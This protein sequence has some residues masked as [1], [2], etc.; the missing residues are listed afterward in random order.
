MSY[1]YVWL[2]NTTSSKDDEPTKIRANDID[3]AREI[4]KKY[5]GNRFRFGG[6][7]HDA[8]FK[9]IYPGWYK[10]LDGKARNEK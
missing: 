4:A 8:E 10:L 7:F 3:E 2:K 6:I 1:F 9:K 5:L